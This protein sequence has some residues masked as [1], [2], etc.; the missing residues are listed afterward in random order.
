MKMKKKN[1]YNLQIHLIQ[2]AS[3]FNINLGANIGI[4]SLQE[5]EVEKKN[6]FQNTQSILR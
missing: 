4:I 6:Y 5:T 1:I 2:P 3:S